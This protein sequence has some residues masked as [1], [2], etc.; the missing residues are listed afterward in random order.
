MRTPPTPLAQILPV[1]SAALD[2]ARALARRAAT[3][4]AEATTRLLR[5]VGPSIA[6]V[7][8]RVLGPAHP[9]VDDATQQ[10]LI[11]FVHALPAYRGDCEPAGYATTIAVRTSLALRRRAREEAVRR[12]ETDADVLSSPDASPS[13]D[14]MAE[15]RRESLRLLLTEIPA[16][17]AEALAMRI[18]LGWSLE[19]IAL[20]AQVPANTVRSRIRLAKEALRRRIASCP[21]LAAALGPA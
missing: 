1:G 18:V 4:D 15:Q 17:Q 6:R 2:E 16:E 19:E 14:A 20:H 13:D 8:R 12:G 5:A 7:V 21:A 9:D 11:G 10:A 3:G